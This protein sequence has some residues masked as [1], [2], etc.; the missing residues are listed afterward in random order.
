MVVVYLNVKQ[1]YILDK[2]DFLSTLIF[3]V[4]VQDIKSNLKKKAENVF[5]LHP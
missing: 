5:R 2:D 4:V 3:G 1:N